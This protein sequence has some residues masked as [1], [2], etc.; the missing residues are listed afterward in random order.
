MRL[1][2]LSYNTERMQCKLSLTRYEQKSLAPEDHQ[3]R[4]IEKMFNVG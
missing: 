2:R 3:V 4:G 1:P